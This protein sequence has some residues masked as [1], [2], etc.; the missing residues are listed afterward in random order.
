M[1]RVVDIK[2]DSNFCLEEAPWMQWG[3]IKY[4]LERGFLSPRGAVQYAVKN[5]TVDSSAEHYELACL[6]GDDVNE[7][8]QHVS[9]LASEFPRD[10]ERE[11]K[12]WIFLIFL[13][14]FRNR[15]SYRDPLGVVEELYADFGYP[16]SVSSFVRYM[17]TANASLEGDEWLFK[18]WSDM[19]DVLRRELQVKGTK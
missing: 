17:P 2:L 10:T 12:V 1:G 9:N 3:D 13:W 18:N 14:V 6:A 8:M 16:V 5:L 11:E 7:V 19:L 15:N 4:G